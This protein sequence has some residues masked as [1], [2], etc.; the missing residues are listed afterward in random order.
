MRPKSQLYRI[1]Q[2]CPAYQ[3]RMQD[4]IA[5]DIARVVVSTRMLL[6]YALPQ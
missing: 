1:I 6:Q 2:L 3:T 4:C 5:A